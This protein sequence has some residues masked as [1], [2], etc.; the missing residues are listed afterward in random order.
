MPIRRPKGGQVLDASTWGWNS[1][2]NTERAFVEYGIAHLKT[3]WGALHRVSLY[4]WR[5]GV[6]VATALVLSRLE[7][8]Y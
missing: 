4:P 1:Y 8:R 2:I 6:I 7:N 3:C 5:I